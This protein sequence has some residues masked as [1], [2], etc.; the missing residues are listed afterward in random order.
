MTATPPTREFKIV[1]FSTYT[2]NFCGINQLFAIL[3]G[4]QKDVFVMQIRFAQDTSGIDKL[5][6]L[7]KFEG[8]SS[9][10]ETSAKISFVPFFLSATFCGFTS[11]VSFFFLGERCITN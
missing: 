1:L 4:R 8:I 6:E 7:G 9:L 5:R 3:L 11:C 10:M 2:S